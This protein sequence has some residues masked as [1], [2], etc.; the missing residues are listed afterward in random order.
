MTKAGAE[1]ELRCICSRRPLLA[2]AGRDTLGEPFVWLKVYKAKKLYAEV[3]ATAGTVRIRCR[4]CLRWHLV[5]IRK[6]V[7][8]EPTELPER[9]PVS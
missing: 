3:V 8:I 6:Q 9:I 1:I 4:E 5:T 2:K 7:E